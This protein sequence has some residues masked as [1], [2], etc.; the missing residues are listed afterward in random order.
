VRQSIRKPVSPVVV[1]LVG[2]L[3]LSVLG[4]TAYIA[5]GTLQAPPPAPSPQAVA[6]PGP[7]GNCDFLKPGA[8]VGPGMGAASCALVG[9][10]I[11]SISF[12][13][14]TLPSGVALT[15]RQAGGKPAP[16]P[17]VPVIAGTA[18]LTVPVKGYE[19]D[20]GTTSALPGDAIVI[21]DFTPL[22]SGDADFG[23]ALRCTPT[24]CV[25]VVVS[26]KSRYAMGDYSPEGRPVGTPLNG[27]AS[28]QPGRASRLVV[29]MKGATV[30][31][32]LDG[33]VLAR[34]TTS[35]ASAPAPIAFI[36]VNQDL[37][38]ATVGLSSLS[39][40]QIGS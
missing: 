37:K 19:L 38:P 18:Q 26:P 28:V 21:A 11:V 31:A 6:S 9:A 1:A 3:V 14:A 17:A 16:P 12:R 20:V 30:E 34:A 25:R 35:D 13:S 24:Q 27:E 4:G 5:V 7:A 40:Y 33:K 39:A 15:A 32:W 23:L 29:L 2:L 36:D 8:S 22:T 10:P